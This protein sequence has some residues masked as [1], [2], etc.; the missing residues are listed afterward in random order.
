MTNDVRVFPISKSQLNAEDLRFR[1]L[2]DISDAS[3]VDV[4]KLASVLQS[5][6]GTG[7]DRLKAL[8]AFVWV[9][10]RREDKSLTFD[11]VMNGRVEVAEDASENP[12]MPD[13]ETPS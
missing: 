1:D 3:G 6:T 11:D 12:I 7:A 13:Q 8:A 4:M 10:Y 5:K 9:I 2:V